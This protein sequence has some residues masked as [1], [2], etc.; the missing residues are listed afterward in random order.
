M[1]EGSR[2]GIVTQFNALRA[3]YTSLKELAGKNGNVA[4][5]MLSRL[6]GDRAGYLEAVERYRDT[7][8][9]LN[10]QANS[11]LQGLSDQ[12]LDV[13]INTDR[14]GIEGAWSTPGLFRSMQGL[15]G[16]FTRQCNRILKFSDSILA[17]VDEAYY[18]FHD[19]AGF[20]LLSPPA[21]NLEKHALAMHRL[22]QAS[23]DFCRHPKQ[24]LTEKHFLVP[25]FY[26][27]LVAEARKVFE[28]T[29]DDLKSWLRSALVPLNTAV[30]EHERALA[31]RVDN[32]RKLQHNL[33]AVGDRTSQIEQQL[34][35]LK[36]QHDTLM[37]IKQ[38]LDAEAAIAPTQASLAPAPQTP[39]LGAANE[40]NAGPPQH[41]NSVQAA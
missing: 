3:E 14:R 41:A 8:D 31:L 29:R 6:E 11:L 40:A 35:A 18:H 19:K 12:A 13:L 24:I 23:V 4:Q 30:R 36:S 38:R 1:L 27:N 33:N 9:V 10:K 32:L 16:H 28:A 39:T 17:L 34:R 25:Q 26:N 20:N 15:F 2:Q 37:T 5:A 21:F 7:L 22:Q